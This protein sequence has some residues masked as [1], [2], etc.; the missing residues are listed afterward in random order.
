MSAQARRMSASERRK[1]RG[2]EKWASRVCVRVRTGSSTT[3]RPTSLCM[4]TLT[5]SPDTS[6]M[7][8]GAEEARPLR[9]AGSGEGKA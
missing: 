1:Q 5:S 6:H 8:Y 7:L 3:R 2:A 4:G 9:R